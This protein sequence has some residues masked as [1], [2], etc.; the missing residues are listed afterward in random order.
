MQRS[1]YGGVG[2]VKIYHGAT[3]G[4]ITANKFIGGGINTDLGT[5]QV[6]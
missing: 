5:D 2:G 6:Y 1:Q 4:I 3:S